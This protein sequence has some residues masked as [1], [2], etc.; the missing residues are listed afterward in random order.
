MALIDQWIQED[1]RTIQEQ[2]SYL[3]LKSAGIFDSDLAQTAVSV[4]YLEDAGIISL[5]ILHRESFY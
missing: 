4:A 1:P 5:V 2:F 3:H